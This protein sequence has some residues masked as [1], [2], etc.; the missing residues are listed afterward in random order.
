MTLDE[1]EREEGES[2]T[3]EEIREELWL[4]K[5]LPTEI[6]EENAMPLLEKLSQL[7]LDHG[8]RDKFLEVFEDL[9]GYFPASSETQAKIDQL[10]Q[11]FNEEDTTQEIVND[12]DDC[13]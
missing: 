8:E 3:P 10:I 6:R 13:G 9:N 11:R 7:K 4:T 12:D 2:S 5:G 1:Q